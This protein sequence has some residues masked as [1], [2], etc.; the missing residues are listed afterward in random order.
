[1]TS[2]ATARPGACR[3]RAT[4]V[5]AF[6]ALALTLA[7]GLGGAPARAVEEGTVILGREIGECWELRY[8]GRYMDSY[9][10]LKAI[11]REN[12]GRMS[13]VDRIS[14]LELMGELF[15]IWRQPDRAQAIYEDILGVDFTWRPK[16]L[17][18]LPASYRAPIVNAFRNRFPEGLAAGRLSNLALL[19]V[20]VVDL[21]SDPKG[22]ALE[23]ALSRMIGTRIA[24]VLKDSDMRCNGV[25]VTVI[26]YEFRPLVQ[27]QIQN[28]Y[29]LIG[30]ESQGNEDRETKVAPGRLLAIQGFV[31]AA[32]FRHVTNK[33]EVSIRL[34]S[35]ETGQQVSSARARGDFDDLF[36]VID[37]AVD[38][39]AASL[40]GDLDDWSGN[41]RS[42]RRTSP[43]RSPD[44][45]LHFADAIGYLE[46]E[47]YA[48][49]DLSLRACLE[50]DPE[51]EEAR[52]TQ[53]AML[54]Q[55]AVAQFTPPD[56]ELEMITFSSAE[57]G[58]TGTQLN[59]VHEGAGS[60]AV[61]ATAEP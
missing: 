44:A 23:P 12:E 29:E 37:E 46:R 36:G 21:H 15:C 1:M 45:I 58:P 42:E 51:F 18:N 7:S 17:D 4:A 59:S 52:E 22:E 32:V 26:P 10:R 8:D 43:T 16:G 35:V 50:A 30:H 27:K 19:D 28:Q 11:C 5:L 24:L 6:A 3:R 53:A 47:D 2:S 14:A 54:R 40:A 60:S 20:I 39:W 33:I 61:Y 38:N 56:T 57:P 13:R 25:P 31:E 48:L 41:Q 55:Q 9:E 49:A 34:I